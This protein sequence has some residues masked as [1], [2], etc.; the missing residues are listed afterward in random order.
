MKQANERGAIASRSTQASFKI[1]MMIALLAGLIF[2]VNLSPT[3]AA[4]TYDPPKKTEAKKM[5]PS[6]RDAKMALSDSDYS[7]AL[8][9][10]AKVTADE[11][12]N[13]DAWNLTG[14]A[15]RK[16]GAYEKARSA[17]TEAL[18]LDPEHKGALEYMGELHLT[19]NELEQAEAL[20][21]RLKDACSYICSERDT[22]KKAIK[23]YKKSN[24]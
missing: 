20:Y 12:K 14:F 10:L 23:K 24:S 13:A 19:L 21:E 4:G 8:N 7:L 15:L 3:L 16:S 1:L 17:Y 2:A 22:L 18:R 6:M 11:P 5:H 9:A